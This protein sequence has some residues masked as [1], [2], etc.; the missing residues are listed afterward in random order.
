MLLSPKVLVRRLSSA[1]LMVTLPLASISMPLAG[2]ASASAVTTHRHH[3]EQPAKDS[4]HQ[5]QCCDWCVQACGGSAV[6]EPGTGRLAQVTSPRVATPTTTAT[7]E[8]ASF[9][10]RLPFSI[11][12]PQ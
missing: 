7:S 11:G 10:T 6:V 4:N 2:T 1:L 9:L 8:A 5:S 12:P 3:H